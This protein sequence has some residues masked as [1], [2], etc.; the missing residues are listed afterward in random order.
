MFVFDVRRTVAFL[1]SRLI[2]RPLN[3]SGSLVFKALTLCIMHLLAVPSPKKIPRD[4]NVAEDIEMF[5]QSKT[6]NLFSRIKF[7]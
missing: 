3:E 5:V 2:T 4:R 1:A 7:P 6:V